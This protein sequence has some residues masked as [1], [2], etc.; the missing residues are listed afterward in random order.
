MGAV[1]FEPT[2]LA[3]E[4][5]ERSFPNDQLYRCLSGFA[6]ALSSLSDPLQL[7]AGR[8]VWSDQSSHRRVE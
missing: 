2:A 6:T 5:A 8:F 3:C 7:G 4:A 1:G